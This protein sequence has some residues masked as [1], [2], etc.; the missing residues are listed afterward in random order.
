VAVEWHWTK[1]LKWF[2]CPLLSQSII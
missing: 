1:H 2:C